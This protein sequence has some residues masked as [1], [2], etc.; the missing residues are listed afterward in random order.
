MNHSM[1]RI[2]RVVVFALLFVSTLT[3]LFLSD[4]LW[5][6]WEAGELPLW[7]ALAPPVLFFMFMVAFAVDR[8]HAVRNRSLA[9]YRAMFHVGTSVVFFMLLLP[10]PIHGPHARAMRRQQESLNGALSLMAS[11]QFLLGHEDDSV[12]AATCLLLGAQG[13]PNKRR[14]GRP[15]KA[16]LALMADRAQEDPS[17]SVREA[18]RAAVERLGGS[19]AEG[20]PEPEWAPPPCDPEDLECVPE[21]EPDVCPEE[22][23]EDLDDGISGPI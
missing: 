19:V 7:A 5:A 15:P 16:L 18:C 6:L 22:G 23:D 13:T 17:P 11:A 12:R 8:L 14:S 21:P 3:G 10:H 4:K 1:G 20:S 9:P 2:L